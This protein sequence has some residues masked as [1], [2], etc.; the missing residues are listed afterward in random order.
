MCNNK[1]CFKWI[2]LWISRDSR[3]GLRLRQL[4]YSHL[5]LTFQ[6]CACDILYIYV[7]I[8]S[9]IYMI[10]FGIQNFQKIKFIFEIDVLY[11]HY[12]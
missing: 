6:K 1:E 10:N 7:C 2:F 3:S 8:N 4:K 9:Y 12:I 11:I 5:K